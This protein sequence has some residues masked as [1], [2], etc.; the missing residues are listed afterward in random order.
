MSGL[1]RQA[2]TPE[3]FGL[4]EEP[5]ESDIITEITGNITDFRISG[6]GRITV[7]LDNGQ[8]WQQISGDST[9]IRERI[10]A[11]QTS[12][13]IETAAMG[14]YLMRLSPSGQSIRVRRI[15]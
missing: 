8:I 7:L 5:E 15:Q 9:S 4:E 13:N 14:T 11:R 12:A 2:K 10:M 1:T 6:T 3:E